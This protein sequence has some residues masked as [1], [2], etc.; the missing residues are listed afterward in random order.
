L[1]TGRVL[2]DVIGSNSLGS[3]LAGTAELQLGPGPR[4]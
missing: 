3:H 1:G 2:L 4:V